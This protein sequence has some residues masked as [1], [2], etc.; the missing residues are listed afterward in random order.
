MKPKKQ[1]RKRPSGPASLARAGTAQVEIYLPVAMRERIDE[2]AR[3]EGR[4]R[5]Q[6]LAFHAMPAIETACDRAIARN[7]SIK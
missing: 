5:S 7:P 2:A 4:S 3:A 1:P 6:F